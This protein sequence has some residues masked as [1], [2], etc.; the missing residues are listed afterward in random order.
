MNDQRPV[1]II[2]AGPNGSGKTCFAS[3]AYAHSDNLPP[4]YINA[5][6]IAKALSLG[7]YEAAVQAEKR[8]EYALS[9]GQ[10]FVME[11]VMSTPK[12]VEL[13][14]EAK[15][16]GYYVRLE[17]VTT[18]SP[19]INVERVRCRV[20]AGGHDVPEE[21]VIS[22]YERSMRLLP[23]AARIADDAF[24]YDNSWTEPVCLAEKSTDGLWRVFPQGS[25]GYWT[26]RRIE[27]L[28]HLS[29]GELS[30]IDGRG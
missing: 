12:K 16:R 26:R 1:L 10:S 18:R 8:R 14:R 25:P 19:A 30:E 11:T 7:A 6:S 4:L 20:S 3:A 9:I 21:K 24:I 27:D 17:Y 29:D 15:K 22:R 5:D 2:F 28:L 13:M 23:E